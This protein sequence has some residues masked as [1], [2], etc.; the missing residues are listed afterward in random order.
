MA[1][2]SDQRLAAAAR[3]RLA[4]AAERA[5]GANG[6]L[7]PRPASFRP[8]PEEVAEEPAPQDEDRR[9]GQDARATA[10][11]PKPAMPPAPPGLDLFGNVQ[12]PAGE[13]AGDSRPFADPPP[14]RNRRIEL[15]ARMDE[16]EVKGCTRCELSQNRTHTVFGEGDPESRLMFVGEGPGENEDLSGRPFVGKAGGLLDKMIAGMKL[17]REDVFIAN[18]VK[19]RPPGNRVPLAG[20]VAA[21]TPYLDRQIEVIRPAVIVTLGLPAT[22]H[23]LGGKAPMGRMRGQWHEYRGIRVM[24]TYHPAYLLRSLH[25]GQPPGGVGRPEARDARPLGRG[26][27]AVDGEAAGWQFT[28]NRCGRLPASRRK[29]AANLS[30]RGDCDPLTGVAVLGRTAAV[31]TRAAAGMVA[32]PTSGRTPR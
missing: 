15:L 32:P 27:R 4:V 17:G 18:V 2:V 22:R 9:H 14:P 20:E 3:A 28:R 25:A 19:C 31:E 26:R 7:M 16:D 29:G 6:V 21:C 11:P 13:P 10:E 30:K 8:E 24:P 1:E 5:F 23:L 12:P